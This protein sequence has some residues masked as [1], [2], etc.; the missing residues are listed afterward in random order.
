MAKK[1]DIDSSAA[2]AKLK[3]LITL[4]QQLTQQL[5]QAAGSLGGINVGSMAG[6]AALSTGTAAGAS[7]G[8]GSVGITGTPGSLSPSL[9]V[10][11]NASPGAPPPSNV[12]QVLGGGF[13]SNALLGLGA[14]GAARIAGE[15]FN[16]QADRIIHGGDDPTARYRMLS[17]GISTGLG[18]AAGVATGNPLIGLGVA[19]VSNALLDPLARAAAAPEVARQNAGI[20][21]S[22]LYGSFY[23]S[24]G[25][26]QIAPLLS[27]QST[28]STG[29][30]GYQ[31]RLARFAGV[32]NTR[33]EATGNP[34][35]RFGD[36]GGGLEEVLGNVQR[37]LLAGGADPFA[38]S[39]FGGFRGQPYANAGGVNYQQNLDR[40]GRSGLLG[41]MNELV[42][43][44]IRMQPVRSPGD[45]IVAETYTRRLGLLFGRGAID[46][47]KQIGQIFGSLPETGG[48]TA[49]I[50]TRFGAENTS[51]FLRIQNEDLS[52]PV[53]PL[54]L[55]Y[56][57]AAFRGAGRS[58]RLG[59]AK[60]RGSGAALETAF[61]DEASAI[62]GLPGGK[63][64]V[65]FAEA[66][67]KARDAGAL[68]FRQQ[69]INDYFIPETQIEGERAR[70]ELIPFGASNRLSLEGRSIGLQQKRI[71]SLQ[72]YLDKRKSS[73]QLTEEEELS[74]T[75]EIEN[76]RTSEAA[77]VA[78][79]AE[80]RENY[81]PA[82][83][84]GRNRSFG[85]FDSRQ[86]AAM[87]YA[88]VGSP[89]RSEGANNGQQAKD[90]EDF[91][92]GF[93]IGPTGPG[94]R[95]GTINNSSDRL[96]SA[97]DRL[98]NLI[99]RQGGG[100]RVGSGMRMGEDA[101]Q[102]ASQVNQKDIGTGYNGRRL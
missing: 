18:L 45:E 74:L 43:G 89:I 24:E 41:G 37:G 92:H 59:A 51:T 31:G 86:L 62:S 28:S 54:D 88:R 10:P 61:S 29:T 93:D 80:G 34:E 82:L 79:L 38:L 1:V 55:A 33:L 14:A 63:D 40:A 19:S 16:Y 53:A 9:N 32:I 49:D 99:E 35:L 5:A 3:E 6:G 90:Q 4:A 67:A 56:A 42:Q 22:P 46:Q 48:N 77:S 68:A 36:T 12:Q 97:L 94:S 2:V 66:R 60:T 50:L 27:Y 21:L 91:V 8:T 64:S 57:S 102:T 72:S 26:N 20:T 87:A 78:R 7:I 39:G 76:S 96:A 25:L 81:L 65:A 58:A 101:A 84:S 69:S 71:R 11:G 15:G 75:G 70:A 17:G 73:G 30:A 52:T 85:L 13:A 98:A 100:G 95:T 47:S 44:L 23:G 83:S